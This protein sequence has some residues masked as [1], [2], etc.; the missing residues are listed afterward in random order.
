MNA[1]GVTNDEFELDEKIVKK[2]DV[3]VGLTSLS[4]LH[5]RWGRGA[6]TEKRNYIF[7]IY[8]RNSYS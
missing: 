4:M 3:Q 1:T 8:C 6:F 7:E 2:G 5:G